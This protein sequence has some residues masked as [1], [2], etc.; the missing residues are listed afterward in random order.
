[1]KW[2]K[3]WKG[4]VGQVKTG[5]WFARATGPG[6]ALLIMAD[7]DTKNQARADLKA[8]NKF[9]RDNAM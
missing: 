9:V 7:R 6:D 8:L 4:G 1:M 2:P 5:Y 3:G